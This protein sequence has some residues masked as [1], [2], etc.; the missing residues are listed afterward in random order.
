MIP[1]KCMYGKGGKNWGYEWLMV[2]LIHGGVLTPGDPS[3][4]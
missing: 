2:R 4:G 3:S 1:H